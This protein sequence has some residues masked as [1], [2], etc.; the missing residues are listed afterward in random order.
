L[1]KWN[2]QFSTVEDLVEALAYWAEQLQAIDDRA[3]FQ[4]KDNFFNSGAKDAPT[5]SVFKKLCLE[6]MEKHKL[7]APLYVSE[8]EPKEP[9]EQTKAAIKKDI[10]IARKA[11]ADITNVAVKSTA[12]STV[13]IEENKQR[14]LALLDAMGIKLPSK[15]LGD[16]NE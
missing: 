15:K 2:I 13:E 16:S 4:A 3:F 6:E 1:S 10:E 8:P 14:Q 7:V 9:D 12:K 11:V 5:C